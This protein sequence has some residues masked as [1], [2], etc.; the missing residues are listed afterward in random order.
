MVLDPFGERGLGRPERRNIGKHIMGEKNLGLD[1]AAKIVK[2]D[3]VRRWQSDQQI[4]Q[5]LKQSLAGR[6]AGGGKI[7]IEIILGIDMHEHIEH[8]G[9][10][11]KHAGARRFG[12]PVSFGDADPG[13]DQHMSIDQRLM[14]H[15]PGAQFMQPAYPGR[16]QQSRPD[17]LDL[18]VIE[19]GIDQLLERAPGQFD[20]H[21]QDH[22]AHQ[23]RRQ[24]V[25]KAPAEQCAA[26]AHDDHQRRR[27]VG[28]RMQ[29]IARQQL[30]AQA[31]C[32]AN[33]ITVEALL[34]HHRRHRHPECRPL[35]RGK[36]FDMLQAHSRFPQNDPA[37]QGQRRAKD[38][39][40]R[41]FDPRVTVGVGR[42][43]RVRALSGRID[44]Q[45]VGQQIGK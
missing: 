15:T 35:D 42:V 27:G 39:R 11:A 7:R 37:D 20:P 38:Q 16:C 13:I 41:R 43:G 12:N 21:A 10:L 29:G 36:L 9:M 14:R 18:R 25:E 23:R 45:K 2:H 6:Q 1:P 32:D 31:F 17:R 19:S 30:R 5:F 26:D 34:D 33:Q 40:R 28:P 8:I 24:Q 44:D 22:E 4:R 3:M